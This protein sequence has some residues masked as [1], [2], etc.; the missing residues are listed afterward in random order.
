MHGGP[1]DLHIIIH[2]LG[3]KLSILRLTPYK[4]S[5]EETK[6]RRSEAVVEERPTF[7]GGQ[8]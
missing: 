3:Q 5:A 7:F 6:E 8:R 2:G 4:Q 1:S